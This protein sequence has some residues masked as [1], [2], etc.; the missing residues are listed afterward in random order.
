[1]KYDVKLK[2]CTIR[3]AQDSNAEAVGKG[4][5]EIDNTDEISAK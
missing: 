3:G 5:N 4:W 1:M 2:S